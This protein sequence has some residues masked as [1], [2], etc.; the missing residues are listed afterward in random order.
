MIWR[1][2]LPLR[3]KWLVRFWIGLFTFSMLPASL[4]FPILAA[5]SYYRS[6]RARPVS[7]VAPTA[8]AAPLP[9]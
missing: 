8:P 5:R 7:R 2:A 9:R 6:R 4:M 3:G 1:D